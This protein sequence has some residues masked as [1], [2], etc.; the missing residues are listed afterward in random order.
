MS[1][2]PSTRPAF[3]IDRSKLN[4][5]LVLLCV[6]GVLWLVGA[7]VS[8]M[9]V[10]RAGRQ[11]VDQW[12]ESPSEMAARRF[13]QFKAAAAAGSKAWREQEH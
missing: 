9:T 11:W 5:G 2:T 12:E 8:A 4:S 3:E 13:D 7:V 1:S 10:F 6:G